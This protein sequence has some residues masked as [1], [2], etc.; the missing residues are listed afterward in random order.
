MN[1]KVI[2]TVIILIILGVIW[3]VVDKQE[4][5]TS[6]EPIKI[7]AILFLT[8]NQASLG[9]EVRNALTL[10]EQMSGA[11]TSGKIELLIEDSQDDPKVALRAYQKLKAEGVSA[12]ISTGDQVSYALSSVAERDRLPL[13]MTVASATESAGDYVFRAFITTEQ[14]ATLMGNFALNELKHKNVGILSINNIFGESYFGVLKK[15]VEAG[16]GKIVINEGFGIGD[17]DLKTQI[18]K[19]IAAKPDAIFVS[20]FGPAYPVAFKQLR[21]FGWRGDILTVNTLAIPFFFDAIAPSDLHDTYFSDTGFNVKMPTNQKMTEF[22]TEYQKQFN[23]DPS[24]VGAYAFDLYNLLNS[25]LEKCGA[26]ANDIRACLLEVKNESGVL[27]SLDF[28][29]H[30]LKVPLFIRKAIE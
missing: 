11:E 23:A 1:K 26:E 2:W 6:G 24:F 29:S 10:A 9:E 22:I 7:G 19:V 27:G 30:D 12:I 13:I 28:S 3:F 8:G 20:G 21:Q 16:G 17:S 15:V 5:V 4:P 25:A 18:T 14:Q